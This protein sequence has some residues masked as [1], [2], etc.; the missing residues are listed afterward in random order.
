M[1][2]ISVAQQHTW[3]TVDSALH[4]HTHTH[5]I[6]TPHT[7]K[8]TAHSTH[9]QHA[10]RYDPCRHFSPKSSNVP[11]HPAQREAGAASLASLNAFDQ[12]GA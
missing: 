12:A 4:T 11:A 1:W 7:H 9:T 5:R 2:C 3:H 8:Y 10:Q 6:H